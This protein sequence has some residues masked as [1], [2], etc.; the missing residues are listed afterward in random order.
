ME[1]YTLYELR[2]KHG[3]RQWEVAEKLGICTRT[4]SLWEQNK[5]QPR[6]SSLRKIAEFYDILIDSL[7]IK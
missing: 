7:D 6:L 1:K 3:L 2:K 5:R 4:Y